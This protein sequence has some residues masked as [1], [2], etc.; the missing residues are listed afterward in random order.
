MGRNVLLAAIGA[1]LTLA[2]PTVLAGPVLDA[3]KARGEL[4]CGIRGDTQGFARRDS[5]GKYSGIEIDMCRAVAAAVFGNADK[6]KYVPLEAARRFPTFRKETSTC[7]RRER[8][9]R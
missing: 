5:A 1:A 9:I 7:W 2:A 8:P 4:I 6:V 3:V